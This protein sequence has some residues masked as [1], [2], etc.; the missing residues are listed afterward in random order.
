MEAKTSSQAYGEYQKLRDEEDKLRRDNKGL[1]LISS[2]S[3]S[4][5]FYIKIKKVGKGN[6]LKFE[7]KIIV[8]SNLPFMSYSYYDTEL[9]KFLEKLEE[10]FKIPIFVNFIQHNRKR[11]NKVSSWELPKF[12]EFKIEPKDIEISI[13]EEASKSFNVKSFN[14]RIQVAFGNQKEVNA[15]QEKD[16][17]RYILLMEKVEDLESQVKSSNYSGYSYGEDNYTIKMKIDDEDYEKKLSEIEQELLSLKKAYPFLKL[18]T[19]NYKTKESV[20]YEDDDED[21]DDDDED[22]Y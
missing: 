17:T 18:P 22:Y 15:E 1:N 5:L 12:R 16:L 7:E 2:E 14:L 21:D 19:F 8:D 20:E 13:G 9:N 11:D 3:D 6:L 4:K 10:Y